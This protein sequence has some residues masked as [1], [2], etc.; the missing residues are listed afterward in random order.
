[1]SGLKRRDE[2]LELLTQHRSKLF[3]MVYALVPNVNDAEDILQQTVVSL[4][5]NF[6]QFELGTNF[7]AWAGKVARNNVY[8]WSRSKSKHRVLFGSALSETLCDLIT[9]EP[10]EA[11]GGQDRM[12]ALAVCMQKLRNR[13]QVLVR[14]C[15][16][17]SEDVNDVARSLD[18]SPSSV[19]NSLRRIRHALLICIRTVLRKECQ[20]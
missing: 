9:H 14:R 8:E 4:W 2:F 12:D 19:Y 7:P 15:Y 20:S 18:R 1:M 17:E 5:K 11:S 16:G 10:D 13:D 3:S 6:E